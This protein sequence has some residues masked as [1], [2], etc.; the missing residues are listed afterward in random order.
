[1][2]L[3]QHSRIRNKAVSYDVWV[4][5]KT[6]HHCGEVGHVRPRCPNRDQP[7][8]QHH[9]DRNQHRVNSRNAYGGKHSESSPRPHQPYQHS[10]K[11]SSNVKKE[12]VKKVLTAVMELVDSEDTLP[13]VDENEQQ[14]DNTVTSNTVLNAIASPTISESK[15]AAFLAA[16]GCPKE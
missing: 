11:Q 9:V 1:M 16:L 7:P 12:Y 13:H 8:V 15:Y 14:A 3:R 5:D 10:S 4:R 2:L 6:C